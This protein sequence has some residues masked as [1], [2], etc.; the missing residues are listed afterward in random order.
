[1][2]S[3]MASHTSLLGFLRKFQIN[4]LC[5]VKKPNTLSILPPNQSA[6]LN[7]ISF[8]YQIDKSVILQ[9]IFIAKYGLRNNH[10]I[11]QADNSAAK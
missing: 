11:I 2:A 8:I 9:G 5:F 1:V 7:Q 3:Y 10:P 6:L 4:S